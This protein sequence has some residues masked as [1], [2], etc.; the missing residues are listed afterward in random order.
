MSGSLIA[1]WPRL[2]GKNFSVKLNKFISVS[3]ET[4][5]T[6]YFCLSASALETST[7][8]LR[9]EEGS[10]VNI[11][12]LENLDEMLKKSDKASGYESSD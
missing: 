12:D 2:S 7:I 6:S 9:Y 11:L 4:F 10:C 8:T 5:Q 1:Q 3:D